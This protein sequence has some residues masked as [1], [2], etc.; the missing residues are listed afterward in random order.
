MDNFFAPIISGTS[1]PILSLAQV[2][3]DGDIGKNIVISESG[4]STLMGG[5]GNNTLTG[6][7]GVNTFIHRDG[8]EESAT[9]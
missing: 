6:G 2:P 8:A 5:T 3:L 9:M 4:D 7:T 1:K